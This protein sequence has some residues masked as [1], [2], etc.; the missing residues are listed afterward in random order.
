V[1][2]SI[3]LARNWELDGTLRAVGALPNPRVPAYASA[4][5]RLGWRATPHVDVAV[6]GRDLLSARHPE[7]GPVGIRD[8][9]ER[10]VYTWIIVRF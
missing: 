4:N 8:E 1:S 2:W 6:I 3:D 5:L 10:S 9:F 7:F